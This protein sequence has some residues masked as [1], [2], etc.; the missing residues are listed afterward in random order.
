MLNKKDASILC[1]DF[2]RETKF[3]ETSDFGVKYAINFKFYFKLN[4]PHFRCI[5]NN[6][7]LGEYQ[8][9]ILSGAGLAV[10]LVLLF[11]SIICVKRIYCKKRVPLMVNI[12][13]EQS[14]NNNAQVFSTSV[15][16][17]SIARRQPPERNAIRNVAESH[18]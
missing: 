7:I 12:I 4:I 17:T 1:L 16:M 10:F 8:L 6:S 2:L 13:P 9:L 11:S 18:L 5:N 15:P 3:C 14:R